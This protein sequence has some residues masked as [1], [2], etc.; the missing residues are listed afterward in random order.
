MM[1]IYGTN[2]TGDTT[3]PAA[4]PDP[5]QPHPADSVSG[6][7]PVSLVQPIAPTPPSEGS[8]IGRV[9]ALL[10]PPLA[11][12][13]GWI[14]GWVAKEVPGAHLSSTQV[15]AF[16]VAASAAALTAAMNW[17]RG[18]QQHE[19]LVAEGAAAPVVE[20]KSRPERTSS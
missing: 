10:T 3:A 15:T 8:V 14:A 17:L 2:G 13:S 5:A 20:A 11:I 9:V 16:M 1:A 19:R 18:W 6:P 12:G 7:G 4:R